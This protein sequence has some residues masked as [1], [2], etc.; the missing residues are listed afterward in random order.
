MI[1]K[2]IKEV[3]ELDAKINT[4]VYNELHNQHYKEIQ[5]KF[6]IAIDAI[7]NLLVSK[8][9]N[10]GTTHSANIHNLDVVHLGAYRRCGGTDIVPAT[11]EG[12]KES[13]WPRVDTTTSVEKLTKSG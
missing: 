5:L 2:E 6:W 4:C 9:T 12:L 13:S 1:I 8:P 10:L 7:Q 3:T 11:A